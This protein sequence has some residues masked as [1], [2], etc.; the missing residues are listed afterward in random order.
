MKWIFHLIIELGIYYYILT[1]HPNYSINSAYR[2]WI[3]SIITPIALHFRTKMQFEKLDSETYYLSFLR[4]FL[5]GNKEILHK[6]QLYA[7]YSRFF[8]FSIS[9][10]YLLLCTYNS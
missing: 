3:L 4:E 7:L 2:I 6:S 9:S 8:L 1:S 10:V 5:K